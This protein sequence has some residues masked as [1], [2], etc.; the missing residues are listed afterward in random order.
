M[1][2]LAV[3][4]RQYGGNT[5]PLGYV[6]FLVDRYP[7][8]LRDKRGYDKPMVLLPL[9][10]WVRPTPMVYH[11][12]PDGHAAM[13]VYWGSRLDVQLEVGIAPGQYVCGCQ[14]RIIE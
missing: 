7:T 8:W 10:C 1:T 14:G 12:C 4:P 2:P 6:Q 11:G 13:E 3:P 9:L 5:P